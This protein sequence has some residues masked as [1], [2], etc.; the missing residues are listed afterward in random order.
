M[1]FSLSVSTLF[2]QVFII[3]SHVQSKNNDGQFENSKSKHVIW[4][5]WTTWSTFVTWF[6]K[7][8]HYHH[9][10][11][12]PHQPIPNVTGSLW[13]ISLMINSKNEFIEVW[14]L[15]STALLDH[16]LNGSFKSRMLTYEDVPPFVISCNTIPTHTWFIAMQQPFHCMMWRIFQAMHLYNSQINI[17]E[18]KQKCITSSFFKVSKQFRE[19]QKWTFDSLEMYSMLF[20]HFPFGCWYSTLRLA[21][22]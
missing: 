3:R 19:L 2:G 16:N 18:M 15:S 4:C 21:R 5:T 20:Q 11:Q 6:L 10:F 12:G 1:K 14:L 22:P 7:D 13:C 8:H 9:E 17:L